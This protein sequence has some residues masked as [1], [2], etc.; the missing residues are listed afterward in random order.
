MVYL[1]HNATSPLR[2]EARAAMEGA[3]SVVGNPS[4]VHLEGRVARR[5]I[6]DARESVAALVGA[7]PQ[8]VI[9]TSGGTEANMLAL[10]GAFAGATVAEAPI[11][12][13]FVSSI[14][15][16]SVLHTAMGIGEREPAVRVSAIP[17]T[18]DGV[19][20]FAALGVLLKEDRG[21]ALIVAMAANNETGVVQPIHSIA[22]L[23]AEYGALLHVD[24]VQACGKI[25]VDAACADYLAISAHKI[26]GPAGAGALI[27]RE[28]APLAAQMLGGGQERGRRA[29]TEN[30]IG[31]VGLGAAAEAIQGE[32]ISPILA[33]RDRYESLLRTLHPNAVFFGS[34]VSRLVNTSNFALPDLVAETA[35][36]SL[37]MDGVMVSA[38]S[39]CSSGKLRASHVL[40]AMGVP[41]ELAGSA[42][43]VSFGWNSLPTDVDKVLASLEKISA[44][45]R[46]R[47]AA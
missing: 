28:G 11:T 33:L 31:V 17:V 27:V 42:L 20:D 10:Q 36:I 7:R 19:I 6:E 18:S 8:D 5:L 44:R 46:S 3:F 26:G 16:D 4:S 43:R 47:Q 23:A 34:E 40:T 1:D 14:E 37:D 22:T 2:P 12:R 45:T 15:H 24:A 13:L 29:G 9:F 21:R 38:G 30:L 25:A 41:E 32:D 35:V 39:A